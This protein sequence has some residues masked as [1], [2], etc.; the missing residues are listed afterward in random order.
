MRI[1]LA[2]DDK[3]LNESLTN[4][5]ISRGFS[6]DS[7][8]DGEEALYYATQNIHDV[9]SVTLLGEFFQKIKRSTCFLCYNVITNKT[10][11]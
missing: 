5:L 7:C 4:Q 6:V 3:K 11:T 8:Y 2:E 10:Y 9:D 1:L